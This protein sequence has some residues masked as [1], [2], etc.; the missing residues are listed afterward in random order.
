VLVVGGGGVLGAAVL[1]QLLGGGR[2]ARVGVWTVVPLQPAL[3]R[4]EPVSEPQW[5]AFAADTALVVF[6]LERHANGRDEA[7]GR[8][9]PAGLV[10]LAGRLRADG[11]STLVVVVPHTA[12]QLPQALRAGLASMDEGAVAALGFTHLVFM[13]QAQAGGDG[14]RSVPAPARLARWMLS[15][16]HWMVP[17]AEQ[18]VRS[19]TVARVAA[20]LAAAL[21]GATP[22]TRVLAPD[23]LWAAAQHPASDAVVDAWLAGQATPPPPSARRGR[24]APIIRP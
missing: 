1:E 23:V 7:F 3:R 17:Q 2:F 10:A 22:G 9:D 4:L 21:P 13:R 6:D 5:P 12:G 14:A 19:V 18:P 20:R 15:Q 11:V 24:R 8:P 16:L